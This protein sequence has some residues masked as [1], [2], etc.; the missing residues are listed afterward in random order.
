[1]SHAATLLPNGKVLVSG[2]WTGNGGV[3]NAD[4]YDLGL[5]FTTLSQPSIATRTSPLVAGTSLVLTGNH[6][7]GVSSASYGTDKDSPS[8]HPVVKLRSLESE[9]TISLNSTNWATNAFR[10]LPVS[11]LPPGWAMATVFVNGTP[12][13]AALLEISAAI[14]GRPK[15]ID[16]RTLISGAFQFRFT[17]T[18]GAL[19]GALATTNV[20]LPLGNWT[21]LGLVYETSPGQ[22]QFTDPQSTNNQQRFYG[23]RSF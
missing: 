6:F 3:V 2:G 18:V 9:R 22:F 16:S 15:L 12:S 10:S 4:L 20:A 17:N 8:D 23:V 1:M 7:R 13:T 5:G 14:P 21:P 11:G 19:F